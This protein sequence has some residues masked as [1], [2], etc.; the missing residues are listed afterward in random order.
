[1][2]CGAKHSAGLV[3]ILSFVVSGGGSAAADLMSY[4]DSPAAPANAATPF[5]KSRLPRWKG[6]WACGALIRSTRGL[7]LMSIPP[8]ADR[9]LLLLGW[10]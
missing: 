5:T 1:M 3:T 2:Y 10:F 9:A 8:Y 7:P 6:V 4:A